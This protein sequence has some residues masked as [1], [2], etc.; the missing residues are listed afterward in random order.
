MMGVPTCQQVTALLTD[1]DEGAL[2]PLAWAGVRLH[3]GL[4]PPCQAFLRSLRRARVI[5]R[6]CFVDEPGPRPVADRALSGAL[7]L[8]RQGRLPAGP[9][10]HP[11]PE[12][13]QILA[14]HPDAPAALLLRA[15]LGWCGVCRAGQ[16]AD[17]ALEADGMPV[18]RSLRAL[19]P[20]EDQWHWVR[21]GLGGVRIARVGTDAATGASLNLV[22]MHGS[23]LVPA[24]R[25]LGVETTLV[26]AGGLQDGPADLRAGDWI[27][28][29]AGTCHG[30]AT[31][32]G[33]ACWALVLLEG[34][35]QFTGWRRWVT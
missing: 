15:H 6:E 3:L 16:G 34:P 7:A 17:L 8:L 5:A 30:P 27:S 18:P 14:T 24:H 1:L 19:L 28:H 22:Q 23:G 13:W 12:A 11:A 10:H 35:L 31:L 26:L 29:A 20:P 4:C 9:N 21:R 2:G 25:H 33:E 32:P